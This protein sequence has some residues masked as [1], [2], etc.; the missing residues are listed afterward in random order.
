[1]QPD[2]GVQVRTKFI[3][4]LVITS[5][6]P[7]IIVREDAYEHLVWKFLH[8]LEFIKTSKEDRSR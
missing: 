8:S 6:L 7:Y 4:G 2:T 3:I 1:M 5:V